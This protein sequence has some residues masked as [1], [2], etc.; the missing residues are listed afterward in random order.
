MASASAN[1][2]ISPRSLHSFVRGDRA[3]GNIQASA[4]HIMA[5][6]NWSELETR[7]WTSV[8]G[9]SNK[10][11]LLKLAKSV[12]QPSPSPA[13]EIVKELTPMLASDARNDTLSKSYGRDSF[14][15][16]TD[17]AFW[18]IPARYVILRA[19]GDIRRQTTVSIFDNIFRG[20]WHKL[21]AI[22]ER[23]IWLVRTASA[24]FYCSITFSAA[25]H[26]GFRYDS[27]CMSPV[28][29][30]A[31]RIRD[32]LQPFLSYD[33]GEPV[34]WKCDVAI[35]VDNWQALHARGPSPV[36]EGPRVLERIYVT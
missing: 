21:R 12:G 1:V 31:F 13:G 34:D 20:E 29:S 33:R 27:Q 16:H 28:N 11:E 18:P 25:G 4:P 5:T 14:P 7:G 17:T 22:A 26:T 36:D 15:L 24:A 2:I 30:E 19:R 23:S 8:V 35:I 10:T 32:A 6:I 9:I 3:R